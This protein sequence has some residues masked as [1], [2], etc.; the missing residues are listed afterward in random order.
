MPSGP[1]SDERPHRIDSIAWRV[2]LGTDKRLHRT[3]SVTK[4]EG[5]CDRERIKTAI[6]DGSRLDND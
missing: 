4:G 1:S 6:F 5:V 3:P 2:V